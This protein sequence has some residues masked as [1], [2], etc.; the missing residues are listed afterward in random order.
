MRQILLVEDSNMFGRL[1]KH[2]IEN[3]F[4][5]PVCWAKSYVETENLLQKSKANFAMALLDYCLPDAPHGEVIDLV[6]GVGI[7]A[8]VFTTEMGEEF[9]EYI[10]SKKVADYILKE[11]PNSLEY[12]ITA[13][14]RLEK[15][16]N[17]LVLVVGDTNIDRTFI[18][19]VLYVRQFRVLNATDG[20]SALKIL[21]QYP[22]IKL[23]IIYYNMVG[24]DG[25]L[26]CQKIRKKVKS[27]RLAIIGMSSDDDKEIASRFIKSGANDF[28]ATKS[29][30]IEEF[31]SRVNHCLEAISNRFPKTKEG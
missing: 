15:N 1:A 23:A 5:I 24:M 30:V 8:F 25:C 4:D 9:R 16:R 20:A 21:Q 6:T 2:K 7:S 13:M 29:F 22:D 12:I 28:F 14:R 31:Y 18:S 3:A 10:W 11:D 27:D 26:L 19:E 17:T